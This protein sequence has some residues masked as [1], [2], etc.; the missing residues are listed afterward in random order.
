MPTPKTYSID[1]ATKTLYKNGDT[2][3]TN[4]ESFSTENGVVTF[5]LGKGATLSLMADKFPQIPV[6]TY[7]PPVETNQPVKQDV[8][9]RATSNRKPAKKA[10]SS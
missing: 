6:E 7:L 10:A 9:P 3:I 1:A 4:Y 8:K 2:R 5:D